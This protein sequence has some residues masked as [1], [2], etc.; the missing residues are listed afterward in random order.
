MSLTNIKMKKL[1]FFNTISS[2]INNYMNEN[3]IDILIDKKNI[4]GKIEF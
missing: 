2:V 4:Y 1:L 3:S